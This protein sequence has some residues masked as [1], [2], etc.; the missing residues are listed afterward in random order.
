[1]CGGYTTWSTASWETLQLLRTGDRTGA[2][3]YTL[4]GL[5]ACVAAAAAGI[6]LMALV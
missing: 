3:V 5:A 1:L 6:W 4:G 2:V